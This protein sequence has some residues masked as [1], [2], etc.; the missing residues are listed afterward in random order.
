MALYLPVFLKSY[1]G[2]TGWIVYSTVIV[3]GNND[4]ESSRKSEILFVVLAF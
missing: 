2:I 3:I 4:P 1:H